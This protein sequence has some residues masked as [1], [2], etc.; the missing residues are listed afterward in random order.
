[1]E[2][3]YE[4]T[5]Q[6]PIG[7]MTPIYAAHIAAGGKM[8]NFHGW[9]LPVQYS[10]IIQE[11]ESVRTKAGLFDVSHMGEL[12]VSGE[13]ATK[14]LQE[15]L[16]ND[17]GAKSGRAVYSPMC[18]P[19]GGT[20]DDLIVYKQTEQSYLL[21]VNASN[22]M[23]DY[24][25]LQDN[26]RGRVTVLNRSA[27]FAQIALQ[28]PNSVDILKQL[29]TDDPDQIK[30]F[31]FVHEIKVGQIKTMLSRSGYTGEDGFEIYC[32]PDEAL[33]LWELLL[34]RG[35]PCGL[36]PAGLGAR[37][38]L[39][40]EAT[41]PLYGQELSQSISPVMAGLQKFVKPD[42]GDFIGRDA[43]IEQMK[44][45]LEAKIVGIEMLDRAVPRNGYEVYCKG[46]RKGYI[47]SG[48]YFP[49]LKKNMG[50]V[51]LDK[52]CVNETELEVQVRNSLYNAKTVRLPFYKRK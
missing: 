7:Q 51:L 43:L 10:G 14:F 40:L 47:T 30:Y 27:E 29:M 39:R 24:Q 38:T 46:E 9:L 4:H 31:N 34:E 33:T 19:E 37:D 22:V 25:W 32:S 11:H 44:G 17:V 26:K 48:G 15:M 35:K 42:K 45:N 20:V 49:T 36:A 13:D 41:L 23:Q 5:R 28:G 50:L 12:E 3:E 21:V 18:Y 2:K 52:A 1:M 8:V 6:D 16:T